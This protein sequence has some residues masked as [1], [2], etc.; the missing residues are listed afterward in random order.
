MESGV[1]GR[2]II[3]TRQKSIIVNRQHFSPTT[4]NSMP[5]EYRAP[6]RQF[7]E[8]RLANRYRKTTAGKVP[9]KSP[10]F[11]TGDKFRCRQRPKG[12]LTDFEREA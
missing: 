3:K 9:Q 6:C 7:R 5:H 8:A 10:T 12:K 2:Y 4:D 1:G 11:L